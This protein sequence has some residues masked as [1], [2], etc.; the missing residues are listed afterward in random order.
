MNK[1]TI[2]RTIEMQLQVVKKMGLPERAIADM[3]T[4]AEDSGNVHKFK[5]PVAM[6]IGANGFEIVEAVRALHATGNFLG[7]YKLSEKDLI[8]KARGE[9]RRAALDEMSCR[10]EDAILASNDSSLLFS[11]GGRAEE[12]MEEETNFLLKK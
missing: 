5:G 7:I 2:D 12:S 10:M 4:I 9:I 6:A 11:V 3:L 8:E 1:K